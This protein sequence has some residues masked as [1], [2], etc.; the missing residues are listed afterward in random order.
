MKIFTIPKILKNQ[1]TIKALN[2]EDMSLIIK[3]DSITN[4]SKTNRTENWKQS[5]LDSFRFYNL[6]EKKLIRQSFKKIQ[7]L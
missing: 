3:F 4:T 1:L 7:D 5:F 6:S 2:L